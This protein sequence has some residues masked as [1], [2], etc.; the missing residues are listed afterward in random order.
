[1]ETAGTVTFDLH[2]IESVSGS[3]DQAADLDLARI[4]NTVC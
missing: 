2:D 1:M 4:S 3:A